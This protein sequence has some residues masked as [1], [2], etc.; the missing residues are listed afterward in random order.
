[1]A[2]TII[3]VSTS[4][5]SSLGSVSP[6]P[7]LTSTVCPLSVSTLHCKLCHCLSVPHTVHSV[8]CLSVPHTLQLSV[9]FA[10]NAFQSS[11]ICCMLST[12]FVM[13]M[14]FLPVSLSFR[15]TENSLKS[16]GETSVQLSLS[17]T[18][19]SN[20]LFQANITSVL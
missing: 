6:C 13:K 18:S 5:C 12:L 9:R 17:S 8:Q 2:N 19:I 16:S 3:S 11:C 4:H 10:W 15:K 20:I 1:M 7:L 14:N